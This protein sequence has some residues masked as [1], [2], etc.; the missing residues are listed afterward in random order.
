MTDEEWAKSI[1]LRS[2]ELE[3]IELRYMTGAGLDDLKCAVSGVGLDGKLFQPTPK[4]IADAFGLVAGG[5]EQDREDF[6]EN[7]AVFLA[8]LQAPAEQQPALLQAAL[9]GLYDTLG[10]EPEPPVVLGT[11][12]LP[13]AD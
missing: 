5:M 8:A 11:F 6:A 9:N 4:Y 3:D 2:V 7:E 1:G 12:A 10:F 13:G